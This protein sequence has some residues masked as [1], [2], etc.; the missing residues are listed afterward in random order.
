MSV[1][2]FMDANSK[3]IAILEQQIQRTRAHWLGCMVEH[4]NVAN[5]KIN[6]WLNMI[7]LKIIPNLFI[8]FYL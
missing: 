3:I 5:H 6:K 8:Y 2:K 7:M 1:K 4:D